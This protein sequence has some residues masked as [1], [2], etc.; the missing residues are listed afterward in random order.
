MPRLNHRFPR[1]ARRFAGFRRA[2]TGSVSVEAVL[3]LPFILWVIV[4]G[5]TFFDVYKTAYVAQRANA[6]ISDLL[7]R[8]T[9]PIDADYLTGMERVFRF[10][11]SADDED[12]WMRVSVIDCIQDCDQDSRILKVN[13]SKSPSGAR[14][15]LDT[16]MDFYAEK[17]PF[18]TQSD[19]IILVETSVEFIPPFPKAATGIGGRDL[20]HV[21]VNRP[22]FAP[23]LYWE[24]PD[25]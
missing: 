19:H 23:Q 8:E 1:L 24:E 2:E 9:D 21:V 6:T 5:F 3:A 20:Q 11:T 13:W 25:A 12:T 16:D 17:I 4:A 22:R 7:S 18:F 14:E 10:L 15:L